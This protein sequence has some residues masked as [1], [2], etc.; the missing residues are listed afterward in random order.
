MD[1]IILPQKQPGLGP[2]VCGHCGLFFLPDLEPGDLSLSY[3]LPWGPEEWG[4]APPAWE[5]MTPCN[6]RGSSS[7]GLWISSSVYF[8]IGGASPQRE[9]MVCLRSHG[10][11]R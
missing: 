1:R 8:R 7:K 2:A 5:A 10:L 4:F 11:V 6:C 9:E 3:V